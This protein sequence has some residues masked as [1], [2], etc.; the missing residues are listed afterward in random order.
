MTLINISWI[1]YLKDFNARLS[2]NNAKYDLYASGVYFPLIN[3]P[4]WKCILLY[5][6]QKCKLSTSPNWKHAK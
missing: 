3:V 2:K 6:I 4:N 5:F 1:T